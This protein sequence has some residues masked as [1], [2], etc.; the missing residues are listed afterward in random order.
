MRLATGAPGQAVRVKEAGVRV[1][2]VDLKHVVAA[3]IVNFR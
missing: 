1:Q 2:D 3:G